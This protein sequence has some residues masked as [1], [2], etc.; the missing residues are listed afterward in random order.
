MTPNIY[1]CA[2]LVA[3]GIVFHFVMKLGE[4]ET[5]GTIIT[6]WRYWSQHPYTSL[7]VVM[8]AYIFLGIQYSLH[9]L[10]Y[11]SAFLTGIACNSIGDKLRARSQGAL[12]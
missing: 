12:P 5:Q 10:T 3:I 9:E 7:S 6:P 8:A 11:S 2:A 4:L 1:I